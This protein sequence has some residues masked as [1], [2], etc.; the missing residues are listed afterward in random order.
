M[1]RCSITFAL[2]CRRCQVHTDLRTALHKARTLEQMRQIVTELAAMPRTSRAPFCNAPGD[3][4]TCWYRRH[5]WEELRTA[6]RLNAAAAACNLSDG[7]SATTASKVDGP[8]GGGAP[9]ATEATAA[10]GEGARD[11]DAAGVDDG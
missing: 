7:G 3:G 6:Q 11:A 1:C 10:G 8:T 5:H 9:G 2:P 4:Y